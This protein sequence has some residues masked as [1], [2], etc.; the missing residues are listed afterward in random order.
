[1]IQLTDTAKAKVQDLLQKQ[2]KGGAFFRVGVKGGGCSGMTYDVKIDDQLAEGDKIWYVGELQVV[3]DSKSF[4]YLDGMLIDF[5]DALV[6]G[7]FQ[8]KNPN[9]TGSC[10]CGTSFTVS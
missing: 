4:M 7:G 5:Q 3:C 9:A 10:G 8:F 1:M 2:G 6:G